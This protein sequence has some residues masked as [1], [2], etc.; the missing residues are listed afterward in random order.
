MT[1]RLNIVRSIVPAATLFACLITPAHAPKADAPAADAALH[2]SPTVI[3]ASYDIRALGLRAGHMR[4]TAA[5]TAEAYRVSGE[6]R[7]LGVFGLLTG[8]RASFES[9]R[10]TTRDSAH[11]R[12][13]ESHHDFERT[14]RLLD[15]QIVRTSTR[16]SGMRALQG[17]EVD[18][19]GAVIRG[20]HCLINQRLFTG[21]SAYLI[22][23]IDQHLEVADDGMPARRCDYV[24]TD[25][26]TGARSRVSVWTVQVHG[27]ELMTRAE[28][29]GNKRISVN[30]TSWRDAA[31]A[32]PRLVAAF[33]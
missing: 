11:Y 7:S 13:S 5:H 19:L 27:V 1:D 29:R 26:D 31:D 21:L 6:A 3:T 2:A 30:L 10:S 8:W 4:I 23:L 28:V 20:P 12:V 18:A 14:T 17:R 22:E 9:A 32:N 24:T 33:D 15:N 16:E 25:I